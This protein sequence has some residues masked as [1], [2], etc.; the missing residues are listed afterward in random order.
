MT[1]LLGHATDVS[2]LHFSIISNKKD[3]VSS[4]KDYM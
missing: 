3:L 2:V 1:D 4:E